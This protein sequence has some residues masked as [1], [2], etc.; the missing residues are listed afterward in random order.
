MRPVVRLTKLRL[1]LLGNFD[2]HD[3]PIPFYEVASACGMPPGTLGRYSRGEKP[4]LQHHLLALADYFHVDPED[5]W[6][7]VEIEFPES[8]AHVG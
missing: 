1:L 5:L 6:G 4:Y 8:E 7:W 2:D 3:L